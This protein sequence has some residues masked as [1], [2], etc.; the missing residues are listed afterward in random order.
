MSL[1]DGFHFL[2]TDEVYKASPVVYLS[3]RAAALRGDMAA[4]FTDE[5]GSVHQPTGGDT[6]DDPRSVA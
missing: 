5:T 2:P 1:N 4:I 3:L 6:R